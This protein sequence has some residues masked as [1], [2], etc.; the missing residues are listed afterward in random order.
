VSLQ[1]SPSDYLGPSTG[2][3]KSYAENYV[4]MVVNPWC[5]TLLRLCDPTIAPTCLFKLFSNTT[6][7]MNTSLGATVFAMHTRLS[8]FNASQP[9][10]AFGLTTPP[11]ATA[12]VYD[13]T[14]GCIMTPASYD[15]STV[16]SARS[17]FIWN[18]LS[19]TVPATS[20]S[21]WAYDFGPTQ[22]ELTSAMAESRILAAAMR[23][24]IIGLPTG[25]FM[26]NGKL[27]CAQLP[28][29]YSA[30]PVT[31]QDY[32]TLETKGRASHV[33]LEQVRIE[34]TKTLFMTL[35]STG[36]FAM[37][38]SFL[39]AAGIFASS[40]TQGR[41]L[42]PS[43]NTAITTNGDPFCGIVPYN[44]VNQGIYPG[45]PV[46]GTAV[47]AN[48]ADAYNADATTLLVFALF[49]AQSGLTVE[50]DYAMT[51]EFIPNPTAPP[52]FEAAVQLPNTLALDHIYATT[53]AMTMMKPRL[54][55]SNMDTT[56][57]GV[58][59]RVGAEGLSRRTNMSRG[60]SS[61]MCAEGMKVLRGM[62]PVRAVPAEGFWDFDW[63][64]QGS[65]GDDEGNGASW[66]FSGKPRKL[67]GQT[68]Y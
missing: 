54:F 21:A 56:A 19:S 30:F 58:S 26:A 61:R 32:V 8:R 25:Q 29:N 63:L 36:K 49:G 43:G 59:M 45:Y 11:T 37:S 22:T 13:Y 27:Y 44:A 15:P 67:R 68:I 65:F 34:G 40:G 38:S 14:P 6:A 12:T 42:F 53:A 18:G 62:R 48:A 23:I 39:P 1:A 5:G 20:S 57:V 16:S 50:V 51:G 3:G 55:Q 66:N 41:R 33:S 2:A 46:G 35:D 52:G 9:I 7:S 47:A 28:W 24:R 31:E 60:L 64:K 4:D 10:E 17:S